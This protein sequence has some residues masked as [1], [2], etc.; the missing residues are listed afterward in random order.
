MDE[1]KLG[2]L[3]ALKPLKTVGLVIVI[4]GMAMALWPKQETE[5]TAPF[6]DKVATQK[7]T[8]RATRNDE[9]QSFRDGIQRDLVKA[10]S[11]AVDRQKDEAIAALEEK[12]NSL[13]DEQFAA[14]QQFPSKQFHD[15]I[16]TKAFYAPL[17]PEGLAPLTVNGGGSLV[18][19]AEKNNQTLNDTTDTPPKASP[20]EVTVTIPAMTWIPASLSHDVSTAIGGQLVA[21]TRRDVYDAAGAFV[22]I[23]AGTQVLLEIENSANTGNYS[24]MVSKKLVRP[25]GGTITLE[26]DSHD[27]DGISGI[28]ADRVKR[29]WWRKLGAALLIA[30]VQTLPHQILDSQNPNVLFNSA[31]KTGDVAAT[32]LSEMLKIPD[33]KLMTAGHAINL[34]VPESVQ[35]VPARK[36]DRRGR[37][38]VRKER[39]ER[40]L[41]QITDQYGPEIQAWR[42]RGGGQ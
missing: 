4:L 2:K 13:R 25:D 1:P 28:G 22:A 40:M 30:T 16:E 37:L 32:N 41:Q 11:M 21:I 3:Q 15:E 14:G 27:R 12:I 6:K 34:L 9:V 38:V 24:R 17:R 5:A 18:A 8:E 7:E 29:H 23:P 35:L 39:M 33:E 31:E 19:A 10:Q 42:K 36:L 20:E 26:W